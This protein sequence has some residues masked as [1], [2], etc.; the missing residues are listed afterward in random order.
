MSDSLWPYGHTIHG[1]LQ[2]RILEWV[3]FPFSRGPSQ[4]RDRTQVSHT[5]GG[6]LPAEPQGKP[7]YIYRNMYLYTFTDIYWSRKWQPTPVFW[8]GEFHGQRSLAGYST[9]RHK[10]LDTTE[11]FIYVWR[12]LF[13]GLAHVITRTRKPRIHRAGQQ[14]RSS[15]VDEFC[16]LETDFSS[17]LGDSF[18]SEVPF[19]NLNEIHPHYWGNLLYLKPTVR[20][21]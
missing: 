13:Q 8:C 5:E 10:E 3:A 2:A 16:I 1:V 7:K 19:D 15:G 9:W 11:H 6:S 20:E 14:T 17:F 12:N 4:C 21:C 18:R